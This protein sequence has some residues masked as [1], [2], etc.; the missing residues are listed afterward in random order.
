MHTS[1]RRHLA[2]LTALLAFSQSLP[3]QNAPKKPTIPELY[4]QFCASCH[5]DKM[6]GGQGNTLV[7]FALKNGDD[8]DSLF[9]SIKNGNLQAG[10][11]PFGPALDDQTI[12]GL[13]IYIRE[14]R[15][16][17]ELK[18]N[19][20]P[21]AQ[22]DGRYSSE[23]HS[24]IVE[25][26]AKNLTTPWA[27][28]WLPDGRAL[29]TERSGRLQI[30]DTNQK[31]LGPVK[32]IPDVHSRGQGGLL[33]VAVH[34][35]Y[36]T[37]RWIYL[38]YSEPEKSDGKTVSLTTIV[39]GRISD[40]LRWTDQQTIYRAPLKF[41]REA[42]HHYGCRLV[43]H[44]GYL[45]FGIGDRG[46]GDQAQS[47]AH[48]NGKI[49]RIHDDGRIPT[50]NP[51][52]QN[53]DALPSI[54]SYGHRNP[55]GLTRHPA[56]GH[57][58]ETEHGPRGGDELNLIAPGQ[59]YGWPLASYGMNYNGTPLTPHTTLPGKI[60]PVIYWTPSIAACGLAPYTAEKFPAW[61]NNLFAGGL[62]SEELH[63][64]VVDPEG[65]VTH[66]EIVLKNFGRIRDVRTGPDGL[67]YLVLN[68][69]PEA[70]AGRIVRLRP[71]D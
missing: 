69:R 5:G 51:F 15:R 46:S 48:P 39:R 53:P 64:L 63:R 41:Y 1:P 36:A 44:D 35:A 28:A 37:N 38:A 18:G 61:K 31:L 40:D 25:T 50:D 21:T 29:V 6:Q 9:D 55:Q 52:V 58:W 34:P 47:L 49:H 20:V 60:D 26:V 11:P 32:N 57:L 45:F 13:A 3:A 23:K 10:M 70:D 14:Q 33:D 66:R 59:N 68:G 27:I 4:S 12:R 8:A 62:A 2:L 42:N 67:I 7:G 56:T 19:P 17:A 24:F 65:N 16:Q 71:A 22:P 54:W 30:I 43:F